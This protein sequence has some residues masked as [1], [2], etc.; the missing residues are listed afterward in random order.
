MIL[1]TKRLLIRAMNP[2]EL[3]KYSANINPFS[4][5]HVTIA[6]NEID[7]QLRPVL[8]SKVIPEVRSNKQDYLFYT[9]WLMIEKKFNL[10]IGSIMF[11]GLPDAEGRAEIGY[12][13]HQEF[14]NKGFMTEA[15]GAL[16]SWAFETGKVS[17]IIAETAKDNPASFGVLENNSFT[18]FKENDKYFYWEKID[19]G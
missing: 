7:E 2:D 3:V 4:D 15:V 8:L 5:S 18:K 6:K 16:C 10:S 17:S 12:G 11:K 1:E 9:L 14:Q 13:T 19:I